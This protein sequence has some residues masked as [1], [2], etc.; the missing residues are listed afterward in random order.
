MNQLHTGFE[1]EVSARPIKYVKLSVAASFGN[2]KYTDDVSG[3]Y[4]DYSA[5]SNEKNYNFYVKDLYVGD[6]PQNQI[7]IMP[8]FYP[9]DGMKL[10]FVYRIYSKFYSDWD[11]FSRTDE[12]Y[13][14]AGGDR[15]VQS[16][17]VPNYNVLDI[18]F[19]YDLP[20]DISGVKLQVFAH[21]F[22]AL[23]EVYIQDAVDN[24]KYNSWDND[25]DA[26][27][28]EVFFGLPRTINAGVKVSL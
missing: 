24:S 13:P 11:P 14:S 26:D 25:H 21:V 23:D 1:A 6:A 9:I 20:F 2:W 10:Q 15:G 3:K 18:H 28:A 27:D 8:T 7:A 19:A 16:W 17:Q 22:N 12:K 4:I 5:P